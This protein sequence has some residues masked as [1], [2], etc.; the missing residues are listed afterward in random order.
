MAAGIP[1]LGE[2]VSAET[3]PAILSGIR[4]EVAQTIVSLGMNLGNTAMSANL[5]E[6]IR[7]ALEMWARG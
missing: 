2:L 6:G 4:P 1:K 7:M 3:L 5:R